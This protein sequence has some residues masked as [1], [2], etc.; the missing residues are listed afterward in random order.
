[1]FLRLRPIRLRLRANQRSDAQR[2]TSASVP[3]ACSFAA[4]CTR[5]VDAHGPTHIY[6]RVIPNVRP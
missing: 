2:L 6:G 5:A 4:V 1:M 3:R